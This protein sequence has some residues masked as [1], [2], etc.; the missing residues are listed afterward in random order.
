[1][2]ISQQQDWT[3]DDTCKDNLKAHASQDKSKAAPQFEKDEYLKLHGCTDTIKMLL[4]E[5]RIS[6]PHLFKEN[7]KLVTF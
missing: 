6:E 3:I 7:W 1:M 5:F 2:I 4:M